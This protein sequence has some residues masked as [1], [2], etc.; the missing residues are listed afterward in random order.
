MTFAL[1]VVHAHICPA[2]ED[3]VG[4][5]A[6]FSREMGGV[7]KLSVFVLPTHQ[8]PSSGGRFSRLG[9]RGPTDSPKTGRQRQADRWQQSASFHFTA[10][11][12]K[13]KKS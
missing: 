8:F 10:E 7:S 3:W 4:K 11:S 6:C 13:E 9:H 2:E 5:W 1:C 12:N